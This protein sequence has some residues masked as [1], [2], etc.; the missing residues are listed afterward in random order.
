[1]NLK[2][3]TVSGTMT[4]EDAR[5]LYEMIVKSKKDAHFEVGMDDETGESFINFTDGAVAEKWEEDERW[6]EPVGCTFDDLRYTEPEIEIV[7]C[8]ECDSLRV[9]DI[10][11]PEI[12]KYW[13]SICLECDHEW[14]REV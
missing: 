2:H 1:M 14:R 13:Y 3:F 6:L 10:S 7:F 11:L 4:E 9:V 5:R 8:P 12:H